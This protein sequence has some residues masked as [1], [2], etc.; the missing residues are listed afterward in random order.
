MD[1]RFSEEELNQLK[2]YRFTLEKVHQES[3]LSITLSEL[4]QKKEM[5]TFLHRASRHIQ[6]PNL[7]VTA[8][9]FIKRYAF[10][11][12]VFLYA[13]TA[14]NKRFHIDL[15]HMHLQTDEKDPLWLP[16][17]YFSEWTISEPKDK[18]DQ[19]RFDAVADF[20]SNIVTPIVEHVKVESK[21]SKLVLWENIAIYIF[22]LYESVL[23]ESEDEEVRER[24]KD[25]L[26]FIAQSAPGS[27]FGNYHENPIKRHFHKKRYVPE[28]GEEVRVRTTCCFFYALTGTTD[29]CKIC[30]QICNRPITERKNGGNS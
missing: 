9:M 12:A 19:W 8:S 14:F 2:N 1:N 23:S 20:F 29:R 16:T 17:F 7:K 13:M 21:Q 24:A 18:R 26:H 25:D 5:H 30:P 4:L 15:A 22:W 27:L 11:A 6:S 3:H 10:L 28:L